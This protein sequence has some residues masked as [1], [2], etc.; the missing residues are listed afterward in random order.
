MP[1]VTWMKGHHYVTLLFFFTGWYHVFTFICI[2]LY[3]Y[4]CSTL[5]INDDE[6]CI[7]IICLMFSYTNTDLSQLLFAFCIMLL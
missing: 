4:F 7:Y 6:T 2:L 1:D 3:I 5:N